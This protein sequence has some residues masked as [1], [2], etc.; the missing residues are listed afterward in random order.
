MAGGMPALPRIS[1]AVADVHDVVRAHLLAMETS[2]AAGKRCIAAGEQMWMGDIAALAARGYRIPTRAMPYWLL[3]TTA[4]FDPT[5]RLALDFVG[6]PI[7]V[8][9]ARAQ[10]EL[11]WTTR[12]AAESI[13]AAA[14]SLVRFG[15]V[16]PV[17]LTSGRKRPSRS[18]PRSSK[19]ALRKL[20]HRATLRGGGQPRPGP[21]N[22]RARRP[23]A[24]HA[25]RARVSA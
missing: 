25:P 24:L 18:C 16:P 12:P 22:G 10:R 17:A 4:R 19:F 6:V 15:V 14:E 13:Q 5:V 23:S 9:S 11:G 3:W 20:A 7:N 2:D 1:F 8:S 21:G